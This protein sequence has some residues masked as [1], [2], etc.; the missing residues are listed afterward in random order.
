MF[1]FFDY[2]IGDS[3]WFDGSTT[4][5]D[6]PPVELFKQ[7]F[8][9]ET[10]KPQSETP[11]DLIDFDIK[12]LSLADSWNL[13]QEKDIEYLAKFLSNFCAS[14]ENYHSLSKDGKARIDAIFIEESPAMQ[15]AVIQS[16]CNNF[17]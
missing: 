5:V 16:G 12:V 13:G 17:L 14:S 15:K 2:F 7:Y 3:S 6:V 1:N 9:E 10:Y 11:K 8:S 4:H